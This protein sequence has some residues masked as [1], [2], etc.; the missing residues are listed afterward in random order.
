MLL[1]LFCVC[2]QCMLVYER[3]MNKMLFVFFASSRSMVRRQADNMVIS[4]LFAQ[5][6]TLLSTPLQLTVVVVRT[7]LG[8]LILCSML[9]V[10]VGVVVTLSESS[11]SILTVY[12]NTYNGGV[13]ILVDVIIVKP[14]QVLD[15]L[16]RAVVPLWNALLWFLTQV[17]VRVLLP[18]TNVHAQS[19]P[20]MVGDFGLLTQTLAVSSAHYMQRAVEC[21]SITKVSAMAR[22]APANV[23]PFTDARLQCIANSNYMTL[24]L[25]T[26]GIY[27]SKVAK[28]LLNMF[29]LS[30]S[31]LTAPLNIVMYPLLD[32]NLYKGVHCVANLVLHVVV[33][34]QIITNLRCQEGEHPKNPAQPYTEFEKTVMCAPDWSPLFLIFNSMM[35]SVGTLVDN[36]FNIMLVVVEQ[37]SGV[38]SVRCKDVPSVGDVW[39]S[40]SD[41]F[42]VSRHHLKVVG[43][44]KLM[45]AVT[46]GTS[47]AYH[48][49]TDGGRTAWSVSTFPFRID[50]TLGVAAVRYGEV[51]DADSSGDTRTG[52][53]GCKCVDGSAG[54][55]VRCSSVP[56]FTNFHDNDAD[57]ARHTTH[58]VKFTSD[59]T[60]HGMTCTNTIIKVMSLRFSRK[61]FSTSHQSGIDTSFD[62]AFNAFGS[63]G[64]QEVKSFAADAMLYIQPMCDSTSFSCLREVENCF[65]YCMGLH[66]GGR[67]NQ[68]IQL[69]NARDMDEYITLMSHSCLT[70]G[71]DEEQE[72]VDQ[73][74]TPASE[75]NTLDASTYRGKCPVSTSKCVRHDTLNTHMPINNIN[76]DNE[77][78][79]AY[80]I[81]DKEGF[82]AVRLNSQPFVVAG[83]VLLHAVNV[84]Q[85]DAT[86]AGHVVVS[87][88]YDNNRGSYSIQQEQLGMLSNQ[89]RIPL[90]VC[91]VLDST[92]CY[93]ETLGSNAIVMPKTYMTSNDFQLLAVSSEW[94]VHWAV[95]PENSIFEEVLNYCQDKVSSMSVTVGS[96]YSKPRVWSL[97]TSRAAQMTS[98]DVTD[99]DRL[100]S[101]MV[102]P[103]WVSY[104]LT[105]PAC[106]QQF[107]FKIVDLEYI[108]ENNIL[109]TTL[110]TTMRDYR[111][112]GL[113][114]EDCVPEYRRYFLNP[115]RHDC[116]EPDESEKAMFSCW[117]REDSGMF[118]DMETIDDISSTY[119]VLCPALQRMPYFGSLYTESVLIA[120]SAF[121]V[122]LELATVLITVWASKK[123]LSLADLFALRIGQP[124]FHHLLDSGGSTIFDF[125]STI[126][127]IDRCA[128]YASDAIVKS[129]RVFA[130]GPGY[131]TIQ[132][133][134]IGTAKIFQH[135]AGTVPLRGPL[136]RQVRKISQMGKQQL[137][138][139][140]DVTW[141]KTGKDKPSVVTTTM[142]W[143][144]QQVSAVK[145]TFRLMRTVTVKSL[146]AT[147]RKQAAAGKRAIKAAVDSA[148]KRAANSA[149]VMASRQHTKTLQV[150]TLMETQQLLSAVLYEAESD[151]ER[152][153]LDNIRVICDGLGQ[154]FGTDNSF[155]RTLKQGCLL[156]P[157]SLQSIMTFLNVLLV[158]YPTMACVCNVPEQQQ[159]VEF[160]AGVCLLNEMPNTWRAWIFNTQRQTADEVLS[161]CHTTMD[162]AN[163]KLLTAFDP[164]FS[165]LYKLSTAMNG[166]FDLLSVILQMDTGTCND[167]AR[168][169]FV[170]SL[171]PEPADYFM[172]CMH[173]GDCRIKCLD[174]YTAFDAALARLTV[175]PVKSVTLAVPIESKFFS[176]DDIENNRH[177]P[178]F[179]IIGVSELPHHVCSERICSRDGANIQNRCLVAVGVKVALYELGLAYYCLPAD[180][181]QF[182][183]RYDKAGGPRFLNVTW[184]VGEIVQDGFLLT[185][186]ETLQGSV[187]SVLVVTADSATLH[188]SIHIFSHLSDRFTLLTSQQ[189]NRSSYSTTPDIESPAY[190]L[191]SITKVRVLPMDARRESAVLNYATVFVLGSKVSITRDIDENGVLSESQSTRVVCL[192]KRLFLEN[193]PFDVQTVSCTNYIKDIFTDTHMEICV[194]SSCSDMLSMPVTVAKDTFISRYTVDP[195]NQR[196][197]DEKTFHSMT[198]SSRS[199]SQIIG[200][201]AANP[202][203]IT[204]GQQAVV[205]KKHVSSMAQLVYV[206]EEESLVDILVTGTIGT[207]RSWIQTVRVRLNP[208]KRK[209][210][211]SVHLSSHVTQNV[212]IK[213]EC[214]IDNCVGC[215]GDA[216][217]GDSRFIDVQSKCFAAARCGVRK[218]VGTLVNIRKPLCN[219]G[220]V[221]TEAI[222]SMRVIMH[223]M[224]QLMAK[225]IIGI[226]E[227]THERRE[228][229]EFGYPEQ[230]SMALYCVAKDTVVETVSVFTSAIGGVVYIA[231]IID[232]EALSDGVRSDFMDTR[233]FAR[234]YMSTIALTN[235]IAS[236]L[237]LPIYVA[238]GLEKT[239]SC[240]V[241]DVI[242]I[243]DNLVTG[244]SDGK[245]KLG[246][247]K[248][249]DTTDNRVVAVCASQSM[250]QRMRDMGMDDAY[251]GVSEMVLTLIDLTTNTA[252]G[253]YLQ[254]LL[255]STDALFSYFIGVV[256]TFMD[257][258]Q[259]VDWKH[260]SLPV[261]N[262]QL[263]Y[264][265]V[266]N[267]IPV[268]ATRRAQS[269]THGAFWCTGPLLMLNLNGDDKLVWNP[270]PLQELTARTSEYALYF[271]CIKTGVSCEQHLRTP[272]LFPALS[273]QG[274]NALQVISRCRD[275]YNQKRWDTGVLTLGLFSPEQWLQPRDLHKHAKSVD[276]DEH[277][278][279]TRM[280]IGV[281]AK[282]TDIIDALTLD[283][284]LHDCLQTAIT[285]GTFALQEECMK[286]WMREDDSNFVHED[287][288]FAY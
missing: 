203:Y 86:D 41:V 164:V 252:L 46:D 131:D 257:F 272:E 267:D 139:L 43:I 33:A 114:C 119:G 59:T 18:F 17:F 205:N 27:C 116:I 34:L 53:F 263:V 70:N 268:E 109:V 110:Y 52:M 280:H 169:P 107:N 6:L 25:M 10:F 190:V 135:S 201:D 247:S 256:S 157:D 285:T 206:G 140:K 147:A 21:G 192:E 94:A 266:C 35:R 233:F 163:D 195:Q 58:N 212:D 173:T 123:D 161:L 99:E 85:A 66:V 44:S 108:N 196:R 180:I 262:K 78:A 176:N 90:V 2:L 184:P 65:P 170:V 226:V 93:T 8:N 242:G 269:F 72:C 144:Y 223:M 219:I 55:S 175:K 189:F 16:F 83:D 122:V 227:L 286:Q 68:V 255:G 283:D 237:L 149:K 74:Q 15:F 155:A 136:L 111:E 115:N 49:M 40:A 50:T 152:S 73:D 134:F 126:A 112:D 215:Q 229:Y 178:P 91:E 179:E 246:S 209:F 234:F 177:L 273:R 1:L 232:R 51:Y 238:M 88:L 42:D 221:L 105:N 29:S 77:S 106:N 202:L 71:D 100:H 102:V 208:T 171:M 120:S 278:R 60:T 75:Y 172:P 48:T 151:I 81:N 271:E 57:Y 270:Y 264:K 63:G 158:D 199:L 194:N 282:G 191:N 22:A 28:H 167:Y 121:R 62:D 218:C 19:I 24:D 216:V 61:R 125:E 265:C 251:T 259:T 128:L 20:V 225:T 117:Q 284:K 156:V 7:I 101:Y 183:Y 98:P 159:T 210:A 69:Q 45:Y 54:I 166:L 124:T 97:V 26:P 47:T 182:V 142:T 200:F 150:F 168:S 37:S 87:R 14:L 36:W 239:L 253:T 143:V 222:E 82:A 64:A 4:N 188:K 127:S 240:G 260:C 23:R 241:N 141:I 96:S 9:M 113:V 160:V 12:V 154:I 276:G 243:I 204:Q 84:G 165:R 281:L 213:L 103:D 153:L 236:F 235:F 249:F 224:W 148:G 146:R 254:F 217:Q 228:R 258:L 38:A 181:T 11:T 80:R 13:G 174:T 248:E 207:H 162:V 274:V 287:E 245:V 133:I 186:D 214:R 104:D 288:Y 137:D 89:Q 39:R 67:T 145:V 79:L 76:P 185:L 193:T 56:Y 277:L 129:G 132:P 250:A 279:K 198:G 5:I 92:T 197:S 231:G 30:C 3:I 187:D 211:A 130:G 95:N 230:S 31:W 275:N 220:L 118:V 32:F 244:A 138:K 261:V